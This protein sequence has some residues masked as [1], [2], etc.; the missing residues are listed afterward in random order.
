MTEGLPPGAGRPTPELATL[1]HELVAAAT[2]GRAGPIET[3]HPWEGPIT[4][5][6]L[7]RLA[8][9]SANP[10]LETFPSTAA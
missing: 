9:L 4:E 8:T 3:S 6:R 7:D 10:Y 5:T 2:H 1:E